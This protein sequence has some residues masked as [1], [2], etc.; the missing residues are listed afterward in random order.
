MLIRR[1]LLF[2]LMFAGVIVIGRN[3]W[4]QLACEGQPI[5]DGVPP[6]TAQQLF[7]ERIISQSFIA[8]RDNLNRV[9]ILFQ[10][11]QRQ[12]TPEVFLRLLEVPDDTDN[13]LLGIE[14]YSMQFKAQTLRDQSWR[15]FTFPPI[16]ASAGKT[17]LISLQSPQAQDGNAITVGGIQQ[18]TY[19]PGSAFFGPTPV[20]ADITFRS[21]YKMTA[22]EKLNILSNQVTKNRPGMWG[23]PAFYLMSFGIYLLLII[24]FFWQLIKFQA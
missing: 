10:T 23:Y 13:P 1:I 12:N 11:Y 24:G 18:N 9:D 20:E 6:T 2:S 14:V 4:N 22:I 5:N 16:P 8:P 17:Y 7:G 19:A 15:T 21:C 3:S